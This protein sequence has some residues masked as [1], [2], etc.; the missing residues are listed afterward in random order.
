MRAPEG[1]QETPTGWQLL[2]LRLKQRGSGEPLPSLIG[3]LQRAKELAAI[4]AERRQSTVHHADLHLRPP[5]ETPHR[6][7]SGRRARLADVGYRSALMQ[8]K[9]AAWADRQ[10]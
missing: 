6:S 1:Y 3:V 8:L 7:T 4:H 9:E 2:A 10:W 5:V